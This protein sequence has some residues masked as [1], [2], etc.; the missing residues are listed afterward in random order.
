MDEKQAV[1]NRGRGTVF[2]DYHQ[3]YLSS[4]ADIEWDGTP[5]DQVI[6]AL[7]GGNAIIQTGISMGEVAYEWALY[8]SPPEIELGSFDLSGEVSVTVTDELHVEGWGAMTFDPANLAG[9][10]PGVYAV[11][12]TSYNRGTDAETSED[13]DENYLI[14]L[15]RTS[16]V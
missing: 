8:S 9:E 5:E 3:F 2:V 1:I 15:W 4:G 10:G 13:R 12:C 16:D 14:E 7:A 6:V 11:R